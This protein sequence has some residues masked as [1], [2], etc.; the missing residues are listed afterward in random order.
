[1]GRYDLPSPK[2]RHTSKGRVTAGELTVD[3]PHAS[4][5]VCDR[6]A[7][8]ADAIEWAEASAGRPASFVPMQMKRQ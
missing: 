1:M 4:T 2:C 7:C 3:S 6:P 5:Y 8:I